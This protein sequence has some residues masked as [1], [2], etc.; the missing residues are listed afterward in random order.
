LL[1]K[2]EIITAM[3]K[4]ISGFLIL[5]AVVIA[6]MHFWGAG[7]IESHPTGILT[8]LESIAYNSTRHSAILL[9]AALSLMAA[10]LS[11]VVFVVW[12]APV[13]R[14]SFG[15][16]ASMVVLFPFSLIIIALPVIFNNRV[17]HVRLTEMKELGWI[18]PIAVVV[19]VVGLICAV[20]LI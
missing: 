1:P 11:I 10:G 3:S 19:F 7:L 20:T 18:V 16:L 8:P 6:V 15:L 17:S 14:K 12:K 13:S 5:T 2:D 4:I 9:A